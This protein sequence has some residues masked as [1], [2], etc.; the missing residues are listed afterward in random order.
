M[1]IKTKLQA[2][3]DL[4]EN[5]L[6]SLPDDQVI[7]RIEVRKKLIKKYVENGRAESHLKCNDGND[8]PMENE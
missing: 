4:L 2:E 6:R 5:R 7:E 8:Q 3:I 1:E